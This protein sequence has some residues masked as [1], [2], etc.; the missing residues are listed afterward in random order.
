MMPRK[1]SL[2]LGEFWGIIPEEQNV[3]LMFV[4]LMVDG[5][6]ASVSTLANEEVNA[7]TVVNVEAEDG[8]LKVWVEDENAS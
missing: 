8:W 6:Q 7:M 4:G 1:E 3:R 2:K 5:T